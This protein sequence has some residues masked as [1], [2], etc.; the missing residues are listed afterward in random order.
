MIRKSDSIELSTSL[1][2]SPIIR[3]KKSIKQVK[4]RKKKVTSGKLAV[5]LNISRIIVRRIL[6]YD[7]LLR[8]YKKIVE[9]Q[10]T[11]EHKETRKKLYEDTMKVLFSDEKLLES[12]TAE[13][14]VY[15]QSAESK[16][17]KELA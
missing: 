12:T 10:L 1:G 5:Q 17:I 4:D 13:M 11:G 2:R 8:L 16:L 9:L 14:I 3:T 7:L 6:K 15:G